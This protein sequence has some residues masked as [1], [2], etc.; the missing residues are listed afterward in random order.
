MSVY[1][2]Q[3]KLLTNHD[4]PTSYYNLLDGTADFSK[5][6]KNGGEVSSKITPY[7]NKS[8][9]KTNAWDFPIFASQLEKGAIYTFSVNIFVEQNTE[10]VLKTWWSNDVADTFDTASIDLKTV[11]T[12]TWIKFIA[13][14][15]SNNSGV[16]DEIGVHPDADTSIY[17]GDYM[18]NKGSIPL[19]WNYS[20][21]DIKSKL[22]GKAQ[23]QALRHFCKGGGVG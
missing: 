6:K 4:L 20:L 3:L 22:G 16:Y 11:P 21:N 19:D 23:L 2:D 10:G 14:F 18:L 7:G 1:I 15:K 9:H 8:F 12:N 13:H 5:A 17:V